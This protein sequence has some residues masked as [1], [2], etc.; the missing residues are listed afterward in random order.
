LVSKILVPLAG[1]I[2]LG[3]TQLV[4]RADSWVDDASMPRCD[5]DFGASVRPD[6]YFIGSAQPDTLLAGLGEVVPPAAAGHYRDGRRRAVYGQLVNVTQLNSQAPAEL[7]AAQNSSSRFEV[8]IVPWD[9]T[10]SCEP[11]YWTLSARWIEPGPEGFYIV[12][13]RARRHWVGGRPTFDVFFAALHPYPL[14]RMFPDR[15]RREPGAWLTPRELFS[16]V[17]AMPTRE[18]MKASRRDALNRLERW[19]AANPGLAIRYPAKEAIWIAKEQLT[20]QD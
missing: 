1:V 4:P 13:M 20:K 17:S 9:Y 8:V 12:N 10:A 14:G 7:K 3:A 19:E 18:E 15:R 6:L 2:S 11:T 16:L 5:I